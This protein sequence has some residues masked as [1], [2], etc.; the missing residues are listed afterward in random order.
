[1]S[2][3]TLKNLYCQISFFIILL[4]YNISFQKV[5]GINFNFLVSFFPFKNLLLI[6]FFIVN[7][8][9]FPCKKNGFIV[10]YPFNLTK[11]EHKILQNK[12]GTV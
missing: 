1:M 10:Y 4:L 7:F 2:L 6:E 11:L 12:V 9:Q 8:K 3:L 5:R